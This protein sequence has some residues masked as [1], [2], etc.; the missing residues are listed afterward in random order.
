MHLFQK[1]VENRWNLLPFWLATVRSSILSWAQTLW[2]ELCKSLRVSKCLKNMIPRCYIFFF[3][4][5]DFILITNRAMIIQGK[6]FE[7]VII[8]WNWCQNIGR[9][10][11]T[12]MSA[13]AEAISKGNQSSN[14]HFSGDMWVFSGHITP[15]LYPLWKWTCHLKT[16]TKRKGNNTSTISSILGF[17]KCPVHHHGRAYKSRPQHPRRICT[18]TE[19]GT[20]PD[21]EEEAERNLAIFFLGEILVA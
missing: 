11:K 7:M 2:L 17:N 12:N 10:R 21:I 18:S 5:Q 14:H 19:L 20:L 15:F 16:P 8:T 6:Y 1:Q 9:H 3:T 13:K 4:P